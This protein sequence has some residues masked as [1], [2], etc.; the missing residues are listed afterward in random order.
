M[1]AKVYADKWEFDKVGIIMNFVKTFIYIILA[2]LVIG[3]LAILPGVGKII[4]PIAGVLFWAI[5]K[6]V[7]VL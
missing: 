4:A 2:I 1:T 6:M 3:G 7:G 5:L